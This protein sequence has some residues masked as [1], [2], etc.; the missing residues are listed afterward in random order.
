MCAS[1]QQHLTRSSVCFFFSAGGMTGFRYKD[2]PSWAHPIMGHFQYYIL[3]PKLHGPLV[4]NTLVQR[5]TIET[6]L[7][8]AGIYVETRNV[9]DDLLDILLQPASDKGAEDVFL[10]VFTGP[11]GPTRESLLE[12]I[13]TPVLAMWGAEDGFTPFDDDVKALESRHAG[14]DFTLTVIPGAGHCLHDEHPQLVNFE[15]L[16]YLKNRGLHGNVTP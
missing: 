4:F 1:H 2:V 14:D 9:D 8:Q 6:V 7:K 13:K 12:G 3:G 16:S 10:R 5:P 11:A 15:V